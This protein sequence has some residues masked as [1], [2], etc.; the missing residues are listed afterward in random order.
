MRKYLNIICTTCNIIYFK[1]IACIIFS[2]KYVTRDG[3]IWDELERGQLAQVAANS[4]WNFKCASCIS[5]LLSV[6]IM[7]FLH[8]KF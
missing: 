1:S 7:C 4:K 3:S 5:L 8:Q 2:L 6:I